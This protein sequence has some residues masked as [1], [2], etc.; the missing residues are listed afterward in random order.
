MQEAIELFA[1]YKDLTARACDRN[2]SNNCNKTEKTI[3]SLRQ[4]AQ[5]MNNHKDTYYFG[6]AFVIWFYQYTQYLQKIG[7]WNAIATKS[8]RFKADS[9]ET[10]T[11]KIVKIRFIRSVK[12][13]N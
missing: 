9:K 7:I 8:E 4:F 2:E 5:L 3:N 10:D 11:L 6:I 1:F 13:T 12:F